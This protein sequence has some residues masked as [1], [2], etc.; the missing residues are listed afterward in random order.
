MLFQEDGGIATQ[1]REEGKTTLLL[2]CVIR[3]DHISWEG[4]NEHYLKKTATNRTR[5]KSHF[6]VTH[7]SSSDQSYFKNTKQLVI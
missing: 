5:V 7:I 1:A 6:M 2:L 4:Q 3:G